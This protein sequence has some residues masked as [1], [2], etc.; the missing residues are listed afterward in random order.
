MT[1]LADR[2][3]AELA[4]REI[5][6]ERTDEICYRIPALDPSVGDL[7]VECGSDE[8]TVYVGHHAHCHF[9]TVASDGETLEERIGHCASDAARFVAEVLRDETVIWSNAWGAGGWVSLRDEKGRLKAA[10]IRGLKFVWSGPYAL[11]DA[12]PSPA[13]R[14]ASISLG[15]AV[16][17]AIGMYNAWSPSVR[18]ASALANW[19]ALG[20]MQLIPIALFALSLST[21][22]L[23]TRAL[24]AIALIPIVVV[25]AIFASCAAFE[26]ASIVARGTSPSFERLSSIPFSNGGLT[27][28][29]TNGGAMTSFGIVVRQECVLLPGI[30]RVRD[31]WSAYPAYEV[32]MRRIGADRFQFS[33]PAY[34]KRRRTEMR[35]VVELRPLGCPLADLQTRT[36]ESTGTAVLE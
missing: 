3:L 15:L 5:A 28:Y 7:V 19:I 1:L 32:S 35:E 20:G 4:A 8:I 27:A 22:A 25:A 14:L 24:R 12:A 34:G 17:Y 33:T 21:G 10:R 13:P 9:D 26:G 11:E 29:R 36:D 31:V 30:L 16:V 23:W 18:F 2:C 6:V